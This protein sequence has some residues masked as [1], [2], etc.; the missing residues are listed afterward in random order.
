MEGD[1]IG[2]TINL[3][4]KDAPS[5]LFIQA[6]IAGGY[7]AIFAN[8]P[9]QAFNHN[10]IN[11]KSPAEVNGSNYIAA[12][13]D[14]P[15][16][17][18]SYSQNSRPVNSTYGLTIG[19]R[20]GK[21]KQFGAVV[22]ASYQDIY[23]GTNSSY[24]FPNPQPAVNNIPAFADIYSRKYSF[25]DRR[26]GAY[27]KLD[28]RV[29]KG[30][31]LSLFATYMNTNQ[32]Q[33]RSTVDSILAIQ[34]TGP[35]NGNVNFQQRSTWIIQSIFNVTIQG[36]HDLGT[37]F[38][39]DWSGVYS[40]AK[41][42]IPDQS[43]FSTLESITTDAATGAIKT[44]PL[45]LDGQM[46]REW[47]H[48]TDQD[49]AFYA[50][51]TYHPIIFGKKAEFKTGGLVRHKHRDNY[52]NPYAL[53]AQQTASNQP[54]VFTDIFNAQYAFSGVYTGGSGEINANTY[55]TSEDIDAGYLQ[56]KILLSEKLEALG[57]VRVEHTYDSYQT[58]Q[59]AVSDGRSGNIYYND[60]LPSLQ[61][62]YAL[63][64]KQNLRLGYYRA[65]SR[66]GYFEIVPA[67]TV[68]EFYSTVGN[69]NLNV[70]SVYQ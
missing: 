46:T 32:F 30:Q 39:F 29:K 38:K 40:R 5:Q 61:F 2:G 33:T 35:G 54:Q 26:F 18:L 13:V 31:K 16:G 70:N 41:Q 55:S 9:F 44:T 66:P 56:G 17:N 25:E 24:L 12:P 43:I 48:N 1:A 28:Y 37:K 59:P 58:A 27:G 6:N 57:G 22:S 68:G 19:D 14:F 65:L 51:L 4:M 21:N 53:I 52:D 3:V 34:R 49:A 67:K 11:K 47:F 23:R 69:Y 50:N 7:S 20:F 62:K 64:D 8:Q 60:V 42:Q 45:V 63:T 10:V 15:R 36:D